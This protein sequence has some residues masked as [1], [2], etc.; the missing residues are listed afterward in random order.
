MRAAPPIPADATILSADWSEG[1][2]PRLSK[3]QSQP[4]RALPSLQ[5][6]VAEWPEG[7]IRSPPPETALLYSRDAHRH[8]P[9]ESA[10]VVAQ[11]CKR[12]L[13]TNEPDLA[14]TWGLDA[15]HPLATGVHECYN[16]ESSRPKGPMDSACAHAGDGRPYLS[17][18]SSMQYNRRNQT[19]CACETF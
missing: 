6:A 9:E 10:D 18:G 3:M 2:H 16:S 1:E 5:F 14:T 11:T 4:G 12:L 15:E 17:Q 19:Q 8:T 13:T 7:T